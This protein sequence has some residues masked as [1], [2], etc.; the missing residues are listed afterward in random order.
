MIKIAMIQ[1]ISINVFSPEDLSCWEIKRFSKAATSEIIK[2]IVETVNTLKFKA[3]ENIL[4]T[5][6]H[7]IF[8]L[9]EKYFLE[10]ICEGK[11]L[12]N[13][14]VDHSPTYYPPIAKQLFTKLLLQNLQKYLSNITYSNDLK[15]IRL[16]LAKL[17][18]NYLKII[19]KSKIKMAQ[20]KQ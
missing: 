14:F 5:K 8:I 1:T 16:I 13:Y 19:N 12:R 9:N 20:S 10:S 2:A 17:N 15:D 4:I 3:F 11:R 6:M 18:L 7:L